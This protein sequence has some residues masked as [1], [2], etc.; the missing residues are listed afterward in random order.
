MK[1]VS[2]FALASLFVLNTNNIAK[3]GDLPPPGSREERAAMQA[4]INS[5]N[6]FV[7]ALV[8]R[9]YLDLARAGFDHAIK[10]FADQ[11]ANEHHKVAEAQELLQQWGDDNGVSQFQMA[12]AYQTEMA[13]AKDDLGDHAPLFAWLEKYIL[14][15]EDKYGALISKLPIVVNI[16]TINF[17][18]PVVFTPASSKWQLAGQDNRIEYRK[19]FIPFANLITYYG[20]LYAC[21]VVTVKSGMPQLKKLCKKAAEK[22]QFVMGRYIAA[23]ISDFIFKIA[24]RKSTRRPAFNRDQLRYENGDELARDIRLGLLQ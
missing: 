14:K 22:L 12:F 15:L 3:A 2:L 24:N 11:L 18:L 9:D 13:F 17:A 20:S 6:E 7:H 21:N 10:D 4:A 8:N 23:H 1:T 5:R 19:H 16:R